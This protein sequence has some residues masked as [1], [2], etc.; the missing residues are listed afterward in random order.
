MLVGKPDGERPLGRYR[1]R[2]Y[3]KETGWESM[4]WINLTQD[5]VQ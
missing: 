4:D 1:N 5:R 2:R 3:F